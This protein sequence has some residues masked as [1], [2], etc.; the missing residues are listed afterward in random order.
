MK[1][2]L[3]TEEIKAED[4]VQGQK[5]WVQLFP[6]G[7]FSGRDGRGPYRIENP[8]EVIAKTKEQAGAVR[9]PVDYDHQIDYAAQNGQPAI[10]AGWM[11]DFEVREDG[12]YALIDW[13][14]KALAHLQQKEYRYISPTFTHGKNGEVSC[15]LRAALTN[16]PNLQIKALASA[17]TDWE[18]AENSVLA[19]LKEILG[20]PADAAA[21]SVVEAVKALKAPLGEGD[22]EGGAETA[23]RRVETTVHSALEKM[24][25]EISF[26]RKEVAVKEIDGRVSMAVR[27]GTITPAMRNWATALCAKQPELFEEFCAYAPKSFAH[28]F[29]RITPPPGDAKENT[30]LDKDEIAICAALGHKPEDYIATMSKQDKKGK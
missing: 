2:S 21:Q 8:L 3:H 4:L 26:L 16:N 23:T 6:L 17:E 18:D 5:Q 10:A 24:S 12:V 19:A 22:D 25:A 7:Q 15:I 14:E 29:K 28:L 13:T 9:I 11:V 27:E 20:L 1:T 30:H